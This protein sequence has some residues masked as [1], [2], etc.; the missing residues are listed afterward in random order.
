MSLFLRTLLVWSALTIPAWATDWSACPGLDAPTPNPTAYRHEAFISPYTYHWSPS[1]EHKAVGALTLSRL[2][3]NDRF[4]GLSLF[5]NSFGQPSAYAFTGWA[6]PKLLESQ[7]RIYG[8]VTAGII[9]GYVG[10]YKN[11][12]PLNVGGF[13]PAIIPAVGYRI[14]PAI[15]VEM[16]ILG[17][18]AVMFGTSVRF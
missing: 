3:P 2:L 14:S 7:P 17:A 10:K 12:V 9:Y 5:R 11:K 15:G 6:W 13:S 4:C 16:Q 18:A 1:E 8:T